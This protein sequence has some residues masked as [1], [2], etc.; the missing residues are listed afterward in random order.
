MD[1]SRGSRGVVDAHFHGLDEANLKRRGH[2]RCAMNRGASESRA[3][4]DRGVQAH[5]P[6]TATG[7]AALGRRRLRDG[8][9][10]LQSV[11]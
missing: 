4:P 2:T 1:G 10:R 9:Q 11:A 7:R 5:R 6:A 8:R 3:P